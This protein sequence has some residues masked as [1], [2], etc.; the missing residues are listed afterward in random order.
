MFKY[1][2]M[3]ATLVYSYVTVK[4]NDALILTLI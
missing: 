1:I 4:H 2:I 3:S